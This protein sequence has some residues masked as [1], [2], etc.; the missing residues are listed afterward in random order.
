[1]NIDPIDSVNPTPRIVCIGGGY[2]AIYL[3][4]ELRAAIRSGEVHLTV[5]DRNNY[6]CF[7]GLIPEMLVGKIEPGNILSSSRKLFKDAQFFNGEVESVELESREVIFSRLLD[8]KRFRIPYDHL[9]VNAG[10]DTNL[11]R[12]S[13]LQEHTMRLKA[14]PEI[15]ATR[16]HIISM[17]ELAEIETDSAERNRL[18]TF[19][20]VGGNYAGVEVASEL[21]NFL[22]KIA[23]SSYR[24][25]SMEEIRVVLVHSG[26][27]IL[28]ELGMHY[29]KLQKYAE[30]HLKTL[31]IDLIVGTKMQS[32][33]AEEAILEGGPR[34][35][36][37]TIISCTGTEAHP[38]VRA[39]PF[40]KDTTD[41]L[42]VDEYL[43]MK[44]ET[45][46]WAVGGCGA[47]PHHREGT[48]PPLAIW[49][50]TAGKRAGKNI[51]RVT[52]GQS[53]QPYRFNGL[54]DACILGNGRAVAHLKGIQIR[55]VFAF[56]LWRMFMI[57]YLPS[58]EKKLRTLW[59]WTIG[60]VFGR[61]LINM[62]LQQDLSIAPAIYEPGQEIVREGEIGHTMFIIRS[63][64]V[65]VI[66][67]TPDG[68]K[69]L[70]LLSTGDHFGELAIFRDGRRSATVRAKTKVEIL[71]MRRE[72]AISLNQ[73]LPG[74]D[75][76]LKNPW[77]EK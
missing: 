32:A 4:K 61:D 17:L 69:L 64:E 71:L 6:H 28:P 1:M 2:G 12:F 35:P 58:V 77:N 5:I 60:A 34:I 41:R 66:Q 19:I 63:G 67:N 8:G 10:S 49:A 43:N 23:K 18:L 55:G 65:E 73:S 29:P 22:P 57:I 33:T 20:I 11:K 36:T 68:E 37:R 42:V 47:V 7:H 75:Q 30:Q 21:S 45:H 70:N 9:V 59:D 39:L 26:N 31:G 52:R 50:M 15:L 25:I 44:G 56:I 72:A 76:V 24:N 16:H 62:N 3:Y 27:H 51:L 48:C 46:L 14:Y 74:M 38:V 40:Q 13:G 53:R 54:G